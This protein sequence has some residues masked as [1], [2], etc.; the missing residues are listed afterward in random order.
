MQ[1]KF[2]L[3]REQA[4]HLEY[5]RRQ[6]PDISMHFHSQIEIYLILDGEVEV[7]INDWH[8]V[9]QPGDMSVAF[10][11][12][13]H[14]YRTVRSADCMYI[15]IPTDLCG[16]FRSLFAG[17]AAGDPFIRDPAAFETVRHAIQTLLDGANDL[18]T[19]GCV[20]LTLGTLY[21][22]LSFKSRPDTA[23][24]HASAQL[25]IYINE[26]FRE[27]ITLSTISAAFGYNPSYLSR[28]FKETFGVGFNRYVTMLRLREAVLL[29][30]DGKKSVTT[31]VMES[32]FQSLRSFYRSFYEEF[33]CT[34][35][36]YLAEESKS[37]NRTHILRTL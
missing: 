18:I 15:I 3:R 2:H 4:N 5:S 31:C 10:S 24:P 8:S 29:L 25:L 12:D 37:E 36:E 26:H 35:R 21:D 11:Y 14:S 16:E 6:N 19:R 17:K 20:Y 30:R 22:R 1:A 34:P 28:Y 23:D 27:K 33:G 32:G 9:L 7:W 13:A